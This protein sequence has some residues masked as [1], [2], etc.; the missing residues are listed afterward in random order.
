MAVPHLHTK[1]L[2]PHTCFQPPLTA[3]S[4]PH[5]QVSEKDVSTFWFY[6]FTLPALT[7]TQSNQACGTTLP[8]PPPAP[9]PLLLSTPQSRDSKLC[10]HQVS[11]L[12]TLFLGNRPGLN[13][14]NKVFGESPSSDE[15]TLGAGGGNPV[16]GRETCAQTHMEDA[17]NDRAGAGSKAAAGQGTPMT[18][19]T[20]W[21]LEGTRG[22]LLYSLQRSDVSVVLSQAV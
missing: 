19:M 9:R 11:P 4:A 8:C 20:D 22:T 2:Q 15:V 1:V 17:G 3:I 16:M 14:G 18:Q 5:F 10:A 6:F 7:S 21:K 13:S 12:S